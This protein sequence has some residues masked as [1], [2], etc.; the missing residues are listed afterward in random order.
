MKTIFMII[1]SVILNVSAQI[2]MKAS[3]SSDTNNTALSIIFSS[4]TILA[5]ITYGLSFIITLFIYKNNELSI[6]G[7]IMASLTCLCVFISAFLF[8]NEAISINKITGIVFII[9][10]IYYITK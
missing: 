3:G 5:V 1:V 8:F 9:V 10:G 2:F 7:P 4:K 6:A